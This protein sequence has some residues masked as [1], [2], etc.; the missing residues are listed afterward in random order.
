MN[1]KTIFFLGVI[2]VFLFIISSI[3][4]GLLIENYNF[5][6][7]L[8]SESYAIDT[9]YGL[10]LRF[11][12][13]IPSGILLTLFCFSVIR[14][15]N[16]NKVTKIGFYGLAIFY[17]I[18]TIIVG[19]FPCDK[20]CNKEFIDP[21]IAQIIH[22][23]SGALTYIFVPISI[24]LIGVGLRK[25]SHFKNLSKQVIIVGTLSFFFVGLFLSNQNSNFIGIYQRIIEG[26]FLLF[27]IICAFVIKEKKHVINSYLF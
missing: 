5:T 6:S 22:N 12:G 17:G 21:S 19:F 4:G 2:A 14:C 16:Q 11:F 25:F 20:G 8:I 23:L 27:I 7:Q 3:I 10:F 13:Y 1:S 18:A 24:L 26:L 9:K 15:F